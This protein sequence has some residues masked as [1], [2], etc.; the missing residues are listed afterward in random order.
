MKKFIILIILT[1]LF[2]PRVIALEL[3]TTAKEGI[4]I[5]TKICL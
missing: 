5:E 2:I 4:I 3:A 1:I